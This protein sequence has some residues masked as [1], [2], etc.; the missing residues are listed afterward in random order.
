MDIPLVDI[1]IRKDIPKNVNPQ[2]SSLQIFS[3]NVP[4]VLVFP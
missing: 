2:V 1:E 4:D 3:Q